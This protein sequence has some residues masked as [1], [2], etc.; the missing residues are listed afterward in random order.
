MREGEFEILCKK[1]FD[2]GA[3][4]VIGFFNLYNFQDLLEGK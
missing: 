4:D 2:V 3:F 1:L